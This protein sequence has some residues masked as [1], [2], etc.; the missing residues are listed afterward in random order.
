[1][2]TDA[3]LHE[4]PPALRSGASI[5]LMRHAETPW[6]LP[7]K[8]F[9]GRI[10]THLSRQGLALAEKL[11]SELEIP[12]RIVT[13][14]A[15]RCQQTLD[16]MFGLGT[17]VVQKDNRLHEIDNGRFSGLLE[18]EVAARYPVEWKAWQE[19][20]GSLNIG[21]GETLEDMLIRILKA[22]Y[23]VLMS[24]E[25]GEH[26]MMMTHGG[27]IRVLNCNFA[28]RSL[29]DFHQYRI[30]NL[31]R[32]RLVQHQQTGKLS[33]IEISLNERLPEINV[34]SDTGNGCRQIHQC[35]VSPE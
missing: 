9:Q 35:V 11:G 8:R 4:E 23:D 14:P 32:F 16:A 17:P 19:T 15:R 30:D 18:E 5:T 13:S 26:V 29:N 24:T 31:S 12:D 21:G 28:N 27:P 3:F 25:S 1:M 10:N 34:G 2:F 20:P 7:P 6:N 22:L 33:I